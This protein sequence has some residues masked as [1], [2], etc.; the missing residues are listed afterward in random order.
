M[1]ST[2]G[3]CFKKGIFE[4]PFAGQDLNHVP[5]IQIVISNIEHMFDL[6]FGR[7]SRPCQSIIEHMFDLRLLIKYPAEA[8]RLVKLGKSYASDNPFS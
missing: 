5:K 3:Y 8:K 7:I 2:G 6:N 4:Q 1:K